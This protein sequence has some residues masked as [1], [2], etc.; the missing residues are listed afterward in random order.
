MPLTAKQIA[1]LPDTNWHDSGRRVKF[2]EDGAEQFGVLFCDDYFFDGYD[3][4]P[5]FVIE[6]KDESNISILD[7]MW[8][9]VK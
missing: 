2:V 4:Q 3:E 8:E 6:L 9:Y 5:I 7:V 1:D